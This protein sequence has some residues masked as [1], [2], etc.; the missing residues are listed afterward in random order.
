MR[1]VLC[2]STQHRARNTT[3][4]A[5]SDPDATLHSKASCFAVFATLVGAGA[6]GAGSLRRGQQKVAS[7]G[8]GNAAAAAAS[9]HCRGLDFSSLVHAAI[10][11][12]IFH[13]TL[14]DL[15]SSHCFQ[16]RF[17]LQFSRNQVLQNAILVTVSLLPWKRE[18]RLILVNVTRRWKRFVKFW[19]QDNGVMKAQVVSSTSQR[20]PVP[21]NQ[22]TRTRKRVPEPWDQTTGT[23]KLKQT[24]GDQRPERGS[25]SVRT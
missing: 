4:G 14:C 23:R 6:E 16:S 8:G 18:V 1:G 7:V 13:V 21:G 12:S 24:R 22:R 5:R 9:T 19:T 11:L 2:S 3:Y 15:F 10:L 25:S 17:P 20:G